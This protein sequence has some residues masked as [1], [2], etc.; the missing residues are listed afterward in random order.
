MNNV[1]QGGD[2]I[3]LRGVVDG[4]VWEA[5]SV[6]VIKDSPEETVLLLSPDAEC[7]WTNIAQGNRWQAMASRD[8]SLQ[9]NEWRNNWLLI[10]LEPNKY[11]AIDLIWNEARIFTGYYVNFQLP[12]RRTKL[13]FDSF[14]LELDLVVNKD[15]EWHWKDVADYEAG[16]QS[17]GIHQSWVTEIEQAKQ[18]VLERID[19]RMYLFDG[20][21]LSWQPPS[22]SAPKLPI[23]WNIGR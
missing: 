5:L 6:I 3:L 13:G 20:S 15:L 18:E 11:Y 2:H 10:F 21:W 16:I 7:A 19:Q 9:L 8:W 12:Y 1:W 23:G 4:Q 22:R 17:G 14:D